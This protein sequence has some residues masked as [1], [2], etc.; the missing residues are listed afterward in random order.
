MFVFFLFV[1][2]FLI[3]FVLYALAKGVCMTFVDKR[4][5]FG[6]LNVGLDVIFFEKF[7]QL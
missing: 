3:D 4:E 2:N 7:H 5:C 1:I 6:N